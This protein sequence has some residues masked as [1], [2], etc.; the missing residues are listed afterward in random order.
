MTKS[1]L[2]ELFSKCTESGEILPSEEY[3]KC[4]DVCADLCKKISDGLTAERQKDFS[5]F[6][7]A[8][9]GM[10]YY[11]SRESFKTGVKLG[12]LLAFEVLNN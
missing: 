10:E 1:I 4:L 8:S 3:N 9:M 6:S 11:S 12:V 5:E 7:D 2:E